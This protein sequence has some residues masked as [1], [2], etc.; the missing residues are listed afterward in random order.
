[1]LLSVFIDLFWTH[2]LRTTT[3]IVHAEQSACL[4]KKT[5]NPSQHKPNTISIPILAKAPREVVSK[6][7]LNTHLPCIIHTLLLL[8]L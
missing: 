2:A 8:S 3:S 6:P 1:M 7:L 5:A 4:T